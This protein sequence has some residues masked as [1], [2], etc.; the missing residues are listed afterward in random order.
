M[1]RSHFV[2]AIDGPAA[3]GK[4]STAQWVAR[5]L[6]YSMSTPARSTA[7]STAAQL[8]QAVTPS[9]GPKSNCLKRRGASPFGH[10]GTFVPLIDGISCDELLRGTEV[11]KERLAR[12][13]HAAVRTG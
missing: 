12:R 5:K 9:L 10:R 3:S 1:S 8:V 11:T 2:I 13:P 6:G 4:S 7:R